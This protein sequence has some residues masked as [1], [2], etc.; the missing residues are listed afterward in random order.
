MGWVFMIWRTATKGVA[1]LIAGPQF[2]CSILEFVKRVQW[3]LLLLI[4]GRCRNP[5][6]LQIDRHWRSLPR[7]GGSCALQPPRAPYRAVLPDSV[8]KRFSGAPIP[9]RGHWRSR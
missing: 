3:H 7:L 8:R 5:V 2:F 9:H 4:V 1:V 6:F